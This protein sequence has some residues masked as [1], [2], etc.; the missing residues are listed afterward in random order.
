[1]RYKSYPLDHV[2]SFS[3]L[4]LDYLSG[5]EN[6]KNLYGQLPNLAS[7]EKQ[8]QAKSHFPQSNRKV[9]VDVLKKQYASFKTPPQFDVLLDDK[10]FTVT[11]GHQLNLFTGPLYLIY[12]IV[13]TINL[14]K[15]L[16]SH[17]PEF[18]FVPVY[19]MATEDHDWDE[20]NHF[21]WFGK[22]YTFE[23]D[24]KG[25]VGKFKLTQ[26]PEFLATLP[27]KVEIFEQAYTSGK[28]L[29]DAVRMYMHALFPDEKLICLDADDKE[30]K[31]EFISVME[32][33][34][35]D[36]AHLDL[37]K[38]AN[39]AIENLGYKP[40]IH[41]REINFFYLQEGFRERIE[42]HQ[43]RYTVLNS[44][45]AWTKMEL[46]KELHD[47]PERFSP[48]VVL[49]PIYQE[50][51]LP[52][53]AYLGG[54][55]EVSY[56]LQLKG[57]FDAH[58]VPYPI[59][60]PRNFAL[61]LSPQQQQRIQKLNV[62]IPD[63]FLDENRLKKKFVEQH[64]ENT[65]DF[66]SEQQLIDPIM[67]QVLAKIAAVDK[68]LEAA[69]LAEKH[70]WL[71]GLENLEKRMKKAEERNQDTQ[72]QQLLGLKAKLFPEGHW[73]ERHDNLLN[74]YLNYPQIITDL[75]NTLDA[76]NFELYVLELA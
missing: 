59:L 12:K 34:L 67:D 15:K 65:L 46:Q 33:D 76:L 49:R 7:F 40:Q 27:E 61:I 17:Y 62:S 45:I 64:S 21:H 5:K 26:M 35:I 14:A 6:L 47:H 75:L 32:A 19:W 43:D 25:P 58:E 1:M 39:E 70:K 53:L 42:F 74:F 37:V 63:L 72:V 9:L 56:W 50:T 13:S 68:T 51:I 29:S 30:L 54:G 36:F 55:A 57:I 69:V 31:Q 73:Q 41:A 48:N 38:K 22:K 60:L 8:I 44:Q 3:G 23:T 10:T 2:N 71:S 20:I 52:N 28:T 16:K 66:Q 24:Q 4:L 11:T 18:N